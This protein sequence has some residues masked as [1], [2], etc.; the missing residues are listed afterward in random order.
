MASTR[1][2]LHGQGSQWERIA[3]IKTPQNIYYTLYAQTN[4]H[5]G[6]CSS[7][8]HK[9]LVTLVT[10]LP[11]CACP[12]LKRSEVVDTARHISCKDLLFFLSK[13]LWVMDREVSFL[14]GFLRGF[15]WVCVLIMCCGGGITSPRKPANIPAKP[16]IYGFAEYIVSSSTKKT[17]WQSDYTKAFILQNF[18]LFASDFLAKKKRKKET[19]I[20][21]KYV[22]AL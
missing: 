5:S 19:H 2:P 17:K 11:F 8:I 16:Q 1:F 21:T 4:S 3:V 10:K 7:I 14:A 13:G 22:Y 12:T 18:S 20:M 9:V 6:G 15:A